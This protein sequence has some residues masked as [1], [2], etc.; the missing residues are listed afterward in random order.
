MK[1]VPG[2]VE[3]RVLRPDQLPD[4]HGHVT[5]LVTE[6]APEADEGGRVA[7]DLLRVGHY[8]IPVRR[9][10]AR[11]KTQWSL[12]SS[13]QS[14]AR[15]PGPCRWQHFPSDC[16]VFYDVPSSLI[17]ANLFLN[18]ESQDCSATL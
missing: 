16:N 7:D 17:H 15:Q 13:G 9:S 6:E 4:V 10:W 2:S 11:E 3:Q 1:L 12:S 14:L 5:E 18:N 8:F